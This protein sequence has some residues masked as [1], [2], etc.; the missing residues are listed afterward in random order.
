MVSAKVESYIQSPLIGC[1]Y[2]L[3]SYVIVCNLGL[4]PSLSD[5]RQSVT[6]R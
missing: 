1:A 3:V 2:A 5:F 6:I 4:D